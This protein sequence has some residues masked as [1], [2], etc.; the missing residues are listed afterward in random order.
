MKLGETYIYYSVI[1]PEGLLDQ[2][3][4]AMEMSG[5]EFFPRS[6]EVITAPDGY[7]NK[8]DITVD[9]GHKAVDLYAPTD[10]GKENIFSIIQG[11]VAAVN[12]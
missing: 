12:K 2:L 10:V 6:A 4:V 1:V 3:G 8:I 5:I 7:G 11:V 9:P